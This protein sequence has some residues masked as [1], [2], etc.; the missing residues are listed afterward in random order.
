VI[1]DKHGGQRVGNSGE[2]REQSVGRTSM[3]D[4]EW[5]AMESGVGSKV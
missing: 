1:G 5:E 4:K 3:G 2:S